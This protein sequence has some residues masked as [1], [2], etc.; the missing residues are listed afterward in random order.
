MLPGSVRASQTI[1]I[2]PNMELC[3]SG[4]APSGMKTMVSQRSAV[5]RIRKPSETTMRLIKMD[6]PPRAMNESNR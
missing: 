1:Y 6:D 3:V 5:I 4:E 2:C